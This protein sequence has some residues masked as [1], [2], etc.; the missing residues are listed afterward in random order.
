MLMEDS[1]S[2]RG[3]ETLVLYVYRF[4]KIN[5]PS[6]SVREVFLTCRFKF[7]ENE[8]TTDNIKGICVNVCVEIFSATELRR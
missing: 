3:N 6:N 4:D 2:I 5:L 1:S 8:E 7:A